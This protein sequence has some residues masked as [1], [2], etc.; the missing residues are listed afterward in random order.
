MQFFIHQAS[1]FRLNINFCFIAHYPSNY[2]NYRPTFDAVFKYCIS[3]WFC[4][5]NEDDFCN[6][7]S[8]SSEVYNYFRTCLIQAVSGPLAGNI[9][10]PRND[11]T[12]DPLGPIAIVKF[13]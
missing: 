5:G 12:L 2:T 4:A 7:Y 6:P 11:G 9:T 3:D 10:Y 8:D 13:N 1:F